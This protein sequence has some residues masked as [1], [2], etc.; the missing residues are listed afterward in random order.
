M[1]SLKTNPC[2]RNCDDVSDV[3]WVFSRDELVTEMR[4]F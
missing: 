4:V 1:V 2:W 3:Q